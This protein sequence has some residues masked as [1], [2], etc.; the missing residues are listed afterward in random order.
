MNAQNQVR[1]Y[2]T[3]DEKIPLSELVAPV[4]D[5]INTSSNDNATNLRR[6]NAWNKVM[7][8]YN[9]SDIIKTPRTTKQLK[10]CWKNML[11]RA[12]TTMSDAKRYKRVT[13]GEPPGPKP[14]VISE[15]VV[16]IVQNTVLPLDNPY[17]DD[18]SHHGEDVEQIEE[19]LIETSNSSE[20]IKIIES[21]YS[22]KINAKN[23]NLVLIR[24]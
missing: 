18:Y 6:E 16:G 20:E 11:Q 5:D 4:K 1:T 24:M 12:K 7:E 15:K 9:S 22:I 19:S 23:A 17:D 3:P 14:D 13:G 8:K 21:N 2:F 10:I